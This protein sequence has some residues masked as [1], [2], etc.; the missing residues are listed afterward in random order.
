MPGYSS[1]VVGIDFTA[2]SGGALAQAL[3]IASWSG[4]RVHATHVIDTLVLIE[5]EEALSS[6]QSDI[7]N[8]LVADA[9]HAWKG[10]AAHFP[11]ADRLAL[12]VFVDNRVRG[13]LAGAAR[14]EADLIVLGT[15]GSHAP[16]TGVGTVATGCVRSAK[17]DVLLHRDT[18]VGAFRRIVVGVDFSPTSFRAVERAALFAARDDAEMILLHV[19][20]APWHRVH[21]RSPTVEVA[22]HFQKQYRDGLE[23]RLVEFCR[24]AIDAAGA[25][26]VHHELFDHQGHRSGIVEQAARTNADLIVVG[27]RGRS[28]IRDLLLGSSAEKVLRDT[29]CSVLAIKP[30]A[31]TSVTA[32]G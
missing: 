25:S 9:E 8:G 13:I 5:L 11:G 14:H 26:R 23:R 4:T 31:P 24:P 22:P 10:F 7:R 2:C 28:N 1:I 32:M 21:Y 29:E 3:R 20:R 12:E 17:A 15:F 6:M 19:F 18:H 16:D 30:G 27:T